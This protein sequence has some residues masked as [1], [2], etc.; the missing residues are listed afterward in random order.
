VG[1]TWGGGGRRDGAHLIDFQTLPAMRLMLRW[2]FSTLA[3]T[4]CWETKRQRKRIKVLRGRGMCHA[5]CLRA[6]DFLFG[7]LAARWSSVS[8]ISSG[9]SGGRY[10]SR[11]DG[12]SGRI[13]DGAQ[14]TSG[15]AEADAGGESAGELGGETGAE[16]LGGGNL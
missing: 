15:S 6:C 16:K 9:D 7:A 14:S 8:R 2:S 13:G 12:E 11:R 10:S 4:A 5:G 3:G 1:V